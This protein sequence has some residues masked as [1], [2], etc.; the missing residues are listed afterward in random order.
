MCKIMRLQHLYARCESLRALAAE[1]G[2]RDRFIRVGRHSTSGPSGRNGHVVLPFWTEGFPWPIF[3][4][5]E[6]RNH[7]GRNQHPWLPDRSCRRKMVF[8]A[9]RLTPHKGEVDC[10]CGVR[11]RKK[12]H[13]DW[14]EKNNGAAGLRLGDSE[15]TH[16]PVCSGTGSQI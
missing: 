13:R 5:R 1:P 4:S 3:R 15:K 9:G 14:P 12:A 11:P 10:P 7:F 6:H 16:S 2:L 8:R